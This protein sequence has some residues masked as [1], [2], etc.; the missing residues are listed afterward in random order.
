MLLKAASPE[1]RHAPLH[2]FHYDATE[3]CTV[4]P[5]PTDARTPNHPACSATTTARPEPERNAMNEIIGA[6]EPT[7]GGADSREPRS[8]H[9]AVVSHCHAMPVLPVLLRV[10][11]C[12]H[13]LCHDTQLGGPIKIFCESLRYRMENYFQADRRIFDATSLKI[14]CILAT[15]PH[16]TT[17]SPGIL[18]GR[19]R[20]RRRSSL[21]I[22]R[23]T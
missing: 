23:T 2:A 10:G 6:C 17:C 9:G 15:T 21:I 19:R 7:R 13:S 11:G 14:G 3:R 16:P 8:Q 1:I 18:P 5:R 4:R 22:T 12:C 20:R